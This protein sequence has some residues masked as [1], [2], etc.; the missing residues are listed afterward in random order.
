[1]TTS[2]DAAGLFDGL[3]QAVEALTRVAWNLAWWNGFAHGL[4][5]GGFAVLMIF[6][7]L[8]LRDSRS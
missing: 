6:L 3:I 7:I 4:G 8:L 5:A 2:P 1:M